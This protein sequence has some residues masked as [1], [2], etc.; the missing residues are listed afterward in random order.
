MET[1]GQQAITGLIKLEEEKRGRT[2]TWAAA[3]SPNPYSDNEKTRSQS[4]AG[5]F[6]HDESPSRATPSEPITYAGR[7]HSLPEDRAETFI[8][9]LCLRH[10]RR[11]ER[12]EVHYRFMHTSDQTFKCAECG[13][14]F[15][16][17]HNLRAHYR[18]TTH[19]PF[20]GKP[21]DNSDRKN[22]SASDDLD[23][24]V[25]VESDQKLER[26]VRYQY[27]SLSNNDIRL[28]RINPGP[29]E[30]YLC[31]LLWVVSLDQI[32]TMVHDFQALSYAW[33]DDRPDHVVFLDDLPGSG[34]DG[35]T[36]NPKGFRSHFIRRNLYQA[37][38]HIRLTDDYIWIWVDALCIEQT[39][40]S[41]KSQQIP[42]MPDIYSSAWNVI[43]WLGDD[44]CLEGDVEAALDLIPDILNLRTLD[45][46]LQGDAASEEMLYSWTAFGHLLQRPWFE[47]RWVIQEVACARRLSIRIGE[48]ILSWLDFADAVDIYLE[49]IGRIRALYCRSALF[50]LKPAAL[51]HIESSK[52]VTLMKFSRNIFRRSSNAAEMSRMM[53][54]E[55]LV[56]TASSFAVSDVRDVVYALLYLAK[57]RHDAA[58]NLAGSP[59][60]QTLR[61]DYSKHSADIFED[62]T[63]YFIATSKSLDIICR[64]WASWPRQGHHAEYD[65]RSLPTWVGVA[66]FGESGLPQKFCQPET[67]LGPVGSRVYDASRGVAI[68]VHAI[69][70]T[71]KH[72][73]QVDGMIFGV[74]GS[75]SIC[76]GGGTLDANCLR[77]LGWS[78]TLEDGIVDRLWR[79]L[80]TDRSQDGKPA[81]TWYR[82]ACAL[83][84][85][86]LDDHGALDT[87]ALV[88]DPSQPSTLVEYLRRV[89]KATQN[90]KIFRC[91]SAQG[92]VM[93]AGTRAQE[94]D[95]V[96]G[97][98]PDCIGHDEEYICVLFGCSVPIILRGS[99]FSADGTMHAS[100]L[101]ACYVH[102]YME[103]E[104][105][106]GM[107]EEEIQSKSITFSIH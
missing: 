25:I 55:S 43:A 101:G 45:S 44:H 78:G 57:D 32:T 20:P 73:L 12:L 59:T 106:A 86:Q 47:R 75:V 23:A 49:N 40:K 66:S 102:G 11:Q 26:H 53:S 89:Q 80:V 69:P 4:P 91:A 63:R 24:S 87:V 17:Q 82:R 79:T 107:S 70:P 35:S 104:T 7:K 31:C 90:R 62:F 3:S 37:L 41:E 46:V 105:F 61:S 65:G 42:K 39:N 60:Q 22:G 38:K 36:V 30:S 18:H 14:K 103:G 81:P 96:V 33:G 74:I 51:D 94:A 71:I 21:L 95:T 88:G 83:A 76:I 29:F 52:A 50:T 16:H 34:N 27:S 5:S 58:V 85:T 56:L 28:L 54:L 15:Y 9:P 2:Q 13:K 77:M 100:L 68:R 98:G 6:Y 93:S 97:I 92:D 1:W 19:A 8:C 10:F 84:L 48:V 64:P 67:V 99:I 72:V